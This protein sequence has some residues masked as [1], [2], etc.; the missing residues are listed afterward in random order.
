ME[1][2][3][4]AAGDPGHGKRMSGRVYTTKDGPRTWNGRRFLCEHGRQR[5]QCKECGG[6]ISVSTGASASHA[7]TAAAARSASTGGCAASARSA[8]ARASASMHG[9][10]R[11][12]CKECGGSSICAHGR[13]RIKC[14]ECHPNIRSVA[15][16]CNS[17][18]AGL[19]P[20][21]RESNGGLGICAACEE[22]KKIEAYVNGSTPPP[23]GASWETFFFET[24][25]E[26]GGS[27]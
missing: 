3:D 4:A 15:G 20:K 9:R 17:C 10:Q 12:A 2:T 7:S 23:K 8:E 21:R 24:P 1:P 6:A 27:G 25:A 5:S 13:E 16:A 26:S 11:C 22:H 19:G 18:G 14:R